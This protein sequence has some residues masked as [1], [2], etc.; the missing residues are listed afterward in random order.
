M[1]GQESQDVQFPVTGNVEGVHE[2]SQEVQSIIGRYRRDED[3]Q[4]DQPSSQK[5]YRPTADAPSDGPSFAPET[6]PPLQQPDRVAC[7]TE[8]PLINAVVSSSAVK[9]SPMSLKEKNIRLL[10]LNRRLAEEMNAQRTLYEFRIKHGYA[11]A[12]YSQGRVLRTLA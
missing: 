8:A 10:D 6:S 2:L 4:A 12:E 7:L 3:S 11:E 5:R 9:D 1:S